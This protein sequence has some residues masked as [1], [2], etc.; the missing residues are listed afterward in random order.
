VTAALMTE[1]ELSTETPEAADVPPVP[2]LTRRRLYPA[3]PTDGW[4]SWIPT[5]ILT[6]AA[7]LMH[8]AG[9][10][11][12]KGMIFD[13][14]YYASE[15]QDLIVHGVEWDHSGNHAAYV[16]HPP[17]GKWIIGV[18]EK[19][20]GYNEF[21]WRISAAVFGTL[22]VL[23]LIRIGRRLFRSTVLGCAAGLLMM[24]D[25][26]AFVLG[27]T[28]L[29]DIFLM[30]FILAAFGCLV[31]DRDQRRRRWLR[32]LEAGLKRPGFA[33]PW[34]RLAS[35]AMLGCAM[36]VKWSALWY[37]L[38]FGLL[39]LM[40]EA[41]ARRSAGIRH[42]W[43]DALAGET[44]WLV[45][46]GAV[47][48]I[49]YLASWTGWFVTDYGYDR[50]WLAL[51][52]EHEYPIIGALQNLFHYHQEAL[53]FH[54]GLNAKHQYQSWPWQWLLLGRPVAFYWSSAGPCATAN[55][56]SE[57]LLLGTPLL[58]WGFIPA[59]FG[60]GWFGISRR[61]WRALAIGLGAAAG[62][63]PW[64][65]WEL[66]DRTMFYFYALPAEPFLILTLVYALGALMRQPVRR[67][68]LHAAGGT[69]LLDPAE[70][71]TMGVIFG[72]SVI[73]AIAIIFAYFYPIYVGWNITYDEWLARMWLGNRWI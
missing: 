36:S 38:L 57:V 35:A 30:F 55:C 4:R 16:V 66:D 44:G 46:S 48:L 8:L 27:R 25:G 49:V 15:G 52:G 19:I 2:E 41:G 47:I 40:W 71:R 11:R 56:A 33:I 31:L 54:N 51:T 63:L 17:L 69:E 12:P 39:S 59:L 45:A 73:L 50:H 61:D 62:I 9:L 6:L 10:S 32:A 14:V 20:F 72:A 7:A 29:L 68:E 28:A 53:D 22:A 24:L 37:I 26:L 13:E 67:G 43:A 23:I 58:W 1:P 64:F 60:L 18:G 21:G 70:R 34:W 5:A 65:I 3:M 42:P